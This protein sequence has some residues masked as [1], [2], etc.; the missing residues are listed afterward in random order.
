MG[1]HLVVRHSLRLLLLVVFKRATS[2]HL[3]GYRKAAMG[4]EN[5]K[6]GLLEANNG[7][8]DGGEGLVPVVFDS[9]LSFRWFRPTQWLS[10][11]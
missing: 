4:R 1:V 11:I 9:Y 2:V 5:R 10:L 7:I 6:V 8:T 3:P